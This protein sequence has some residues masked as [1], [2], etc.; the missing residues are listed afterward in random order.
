[1]SKDSKIYSDYLKAPYRV[2]HV[3]E[4]QSEGG[5]HRA[6]G[7]LDARVSGPFILN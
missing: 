7:Q 1:M 4:E 5:S 3:S 2:S 6:D